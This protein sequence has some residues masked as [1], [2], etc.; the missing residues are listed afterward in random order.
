MLVFVLETI[1]SKPTCGKAK[2]ILF[3]IFREDLGVWD[4][5]G[6]R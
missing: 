4:L 6:E 3:P 5:V 1:L 2:K